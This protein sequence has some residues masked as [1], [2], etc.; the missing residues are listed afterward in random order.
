MSFVSGDVPGLTDRFPPNF[1]HCVGG[2]LDPLLLLIHYD[3]EARHL[4]Y[5]SLMIR[6]GTGVT[7]AMQQLNSMDNEVHLPK[8]D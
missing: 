2:V 4:L 1:Q 8:F 3:F 5:T 6:S 7:I